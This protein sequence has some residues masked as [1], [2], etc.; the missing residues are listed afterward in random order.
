MFFFPC[1]IK[2][3]VNRRV[4][5]GRLTPRAAVE[6][7]VS[8]TCIL[9]PLSCTYFQGRNVPLQGVYTD[10]FLAGE[11]EIQCSPH[12]EVGGLA[13]RPCGGWHS[14]RNH[15]DVKKRPEVRKPMLKLASEKKKKACLSETCLLVRRVRSAAVRRHYSSIIAMA[16]CQ[17]APAVEPVA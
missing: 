4:P 12:I 14:S 15:Q 2:T 13:S 16:W 17:V 6:T 3:P 5:R 8:W 9:P 1:N 10:L 7:S 11:I